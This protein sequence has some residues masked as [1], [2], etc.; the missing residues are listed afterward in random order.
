MIDRMVYFDFQK[1]FPTFIYRYYQI[2]DNLV[3]L[4][5]HQLCQSV[6]EDDVKNTLLKF[7]VVLH[8]FEDVS[9][10]KKNMK[11]LMNTKKT[12]DKVKPQKEMEKKVR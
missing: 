3:L 1:V 8:L 6:D 7:G 11:N 12:K 2:I 5:K 10:F 9:M 4:Q